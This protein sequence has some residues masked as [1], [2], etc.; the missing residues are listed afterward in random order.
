MRSG[1]GANGEIRVNREPSNQHPDHPNERLVLP[2]GIEY[3]AVES[4]G[5]RGQPA[6]KPDTINNILGTYMNAKEIYMCEFSR[7]KPVLV[8][9]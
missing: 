9:L 8:S 6:N 7:L 5:T 3:L 2:E 1:D 4:K